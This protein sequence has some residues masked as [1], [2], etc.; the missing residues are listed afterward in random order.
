MHRYGFDRS[1]KTTL[2]SLGPLL[3]RWASH[4]DIW[5]P[6]PPEGEEYLADQSCR[7]SV[8]GRTPRPVNRPWDAYEVVTVGDKPSAFPIE[9]DASSIS[10]RGLPNILAGVDAANIPSCRIVARR[11]RLRMLQDIGCLRR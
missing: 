10:Y 7:G 4:L 11:D 6:H 8:A 3:V 1:P 5:L 9:G 2:T